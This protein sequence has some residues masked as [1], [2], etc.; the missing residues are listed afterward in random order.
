M[1]G[2][3]LI[4]EIEGRSITLDKLKVKYVKVEG[5]FLQLSPPYLQHSCFLRKKIEE[6]WSVWKDFGQRMDFI[7]SMA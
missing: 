6:N 1:G 4:D 2:I 7:V 3:T 5:D